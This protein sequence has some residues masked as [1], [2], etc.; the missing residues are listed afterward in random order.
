MNSGSSHLQ[1]GHTETGPRDNVDPDQTPHIVASD[2]DLQCLKTGLSI[3]N[4]SPGSSVVKRRPIYLAV[5]VRSLLE[6]KY[7]QP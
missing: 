3:K 1:R 2:Q 4:M 6:A 5:R 7:S